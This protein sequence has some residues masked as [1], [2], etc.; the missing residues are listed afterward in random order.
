MEHTI[1][2]EKVN[3][4]K[5]LAAKTKN[6]YE[7]ILDMFEFLEEIGESSM[8]GS[9]HYYL[10]ENFGIDKRFAKKVVLGWKET[11]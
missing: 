10:A 11:Y 4:A 7:Y 1:T 8:F 2:E 6:H 3:K 9:V 5:E